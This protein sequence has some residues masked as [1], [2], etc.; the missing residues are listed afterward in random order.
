MADVPASSTAPS[1]RRSSAYRQRQR[2]DQ[3]NPEDI[4]VLLL[5]RTRSGDINV[6]D[7]AIMHAGPSDESKAGPNDETDGIDTETEEPWPR[8]VIYL[9]LLTG[10]LTSVSFGVTQTSILYVFRLMA[11]DVYYES[12]ASPELGSVMHSSA[13]EGAVSTFSRS[14]A[15]FLISLPVK[16]A[17][18]ETD[19]CSNHAIETN[20]A[21]QI[22]IMSAG[23]TL[24]GLV[25]LFVT[26]SLIKRIGVKTT[27]MI[28]IL[29]PAVRLFVQ[30]IGVEVWGM[31]GIIILEASQIV[32][33]LGG[34]SGYVLALNTFVTDVVEHEERTA[35]LGRLGGA[36]M[37]G[38]AFGFL[39]GGI[40]GD[41]YGIK[42]PFRLTFIMFLSTTLY[43]AVFLP[44]IPPVGVG[45]DSGPAGGLHGKKKR[46]GVMS[47]LFGPM[48]VFTPRKYIRKDGA[49]N[50]EYG[51]FLLAC[52]VFLGILATGYLANL[53]QLFATDAFGFGTKENGW[54]IFIYSAL[55]GLF[56]AFAFPKLIALGRS[57]YT[58]KE[59]EAKQNGS[60]NGIADPEREPL[61]S[62]QPQ[63]ANGPVV[64]PNVATDT[65]A[66]AEPE[67]QKPKKAQRFTFDLT[68]TK[69]SLL[70]DGVLT[71]MCTFVRDGWQMYL[72]AVILP[73]S[74]G[75]GSAAK[76]TILQMIGSEA[77]SAERTD[78]LAGISLVENIARLSTTFTFG[79]IFA[80]FASIGRVELTF[81]CNA[82][83]AIIGGIVLL[84]ARF[85][86]ED[87]RRLEEESS[88]SP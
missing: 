78:A 50:T 32:S 14:V 24:F 47:S 35:T 30:N 84:F 85:P 34:P 41:V 45:K 72:I 46:S 67:T 51:A 87:S 44:Y 52:G 71:L 70:L 57:Y 36:M 11:C 55:R 20:T 69:G 59:E 19:R 61:L 86:P 62:S 66:E 79:L 73:F 38:S 23:T 37:G 74:G 7:D 68:Y 16:A 25:N 31:N 63:T 33:I 8:S 28:Q 5:S 6:A 83:I 64:E 43:V 82:A 56:L 77:T 9:L 40:I 26:G 18:E 10:F 21:I 22:S 49:I 88:P 60:T 4:N 54:L 39:I 81:T 3:D 65:Q 17:A 27:L 29:F 48:T 2:P 13:I 76:G 42:A 53:L 15:S 58:R 80:V 1:R 75:T 12:H